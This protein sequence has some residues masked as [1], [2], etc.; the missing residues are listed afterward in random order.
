MNNSKYTKDELLEIKITDMGSDGE[1]IG[2][3]SR[4]VRMQDPVA[5]VRFRLWNMA[6][7]WNLRHQR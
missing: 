1:G 6:S 5:G 4:N 7:S 2:K 3:V